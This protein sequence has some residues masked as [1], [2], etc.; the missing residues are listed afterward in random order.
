MKT[1]LLAR[2]R[3]TF[4]IDDPAAANALLDEF[5]R[6]LE[7][8]SAAL[9]RALDARDPE[10]LRR[11]GHALKGCAANFGAEPVRELARKLE[12]AGRDADFDAGEAAFQ[13]LLD[14]VGTFLAE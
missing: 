14:T 5:G 9:R 13:A 6:M 7:R 8:S 1:E 10:S 11:A 2:L 3:D 12:Y 4:G